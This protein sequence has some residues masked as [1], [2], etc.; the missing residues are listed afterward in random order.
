MRARHTHTHVFDEPP[1]HCRRPF[2]WEEN[3]F[4]NAFSQIYSSTCWFPFLPFLR[5]V[6]IHSN[7]DSRLCPML[8]NTKAQHLNNCFSCPENAHRFF[9]LELAYLR[10]VMLA[11]CRCTWIVTPQTRHRSVQTPQFAFVQSWTTW[12]FFFMAGQGVIGQITF[13]LTRLFTPASAVTVLA[14]SCIIRR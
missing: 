2:A 10:V 4:A 11:D 14:L 5:E 8:I 13:W 7:T 1:R 9:N 12:N 3:K 6:M